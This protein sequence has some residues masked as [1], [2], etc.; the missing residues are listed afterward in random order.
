MQL[1]AGRRII[2]QFSRESIKILLEISGALAQPPVAVERGQHGLATNGR[3]K[4][5]GLNIDQ[6]GDN[7]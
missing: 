3:I 6:A 4:L 1:H 7:G 2:T 5:H